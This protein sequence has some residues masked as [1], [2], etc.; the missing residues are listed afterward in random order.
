M[1]AATLHAV[2]IVLCAC[3][4]N[5]TCN[6]D[7]APM[8]DSTNGHYLQECLCEELFSGDF[9]ENDDRGCSDDSC[10]ESAVCVEDTSVDV[11]YNCSSCQDGYE[12][13]L[14]GKCTGKQLQSLTAVKQTIECGLRVRD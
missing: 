12:L 10:P 7:T 9:C 13:A 1:G 4:N 5:G 8:F 3:V 11:G 14:D 6:N 2:S